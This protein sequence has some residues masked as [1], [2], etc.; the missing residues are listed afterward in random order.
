MNSRTGS[1][2]R[3]IAVGTI[4][5]AGGEVANKAATFLVYAML[6][7]MSGLEAFGQ[8]SLGLML[9]YTCHVFGYAGLPTVLVRLAARTPKSARFHFQHG[10]MAALA[11]SGISAL[12]MIAIAFAM[13]YQALTTQ[14]ICLLAIAVPFYS[15]SM[16]AEAIIKGRERMY[17]IPLGNL[18]GNILLVAG[19]L[20]ALGAG[21]GVLGVAAVVVAS[22]L[23]TMLTLYA[24]V[25]AIT[26]DC[27][28]RRFR[29]S[30]SFRLLS[31][32]RFFLGSDGLAAIGAS[33]S[34]LILSKFTNEGDVGILNASFQLMQPI[35][36]LYR[37]VGHSSFPSLV[38]A[39]KSG[40][41]SV[42][43]LASSL[44]GLIVRLSFPACLVMFSLAGDLLALA[45]GNEE[46]RNGAFVLQ[47]VAFGLLLDPL[48]A[49]LGH[50]LWAVGADRAV[51]RIAF[52]NVV[53][54]LIAGIVLTGSFGLTGAAICVV[55]T[56]V[57]NTGQHYQLF[58]RHVGSP[59]LAMEI[60]RILPAAL[61]SVAIVLLAP[62]PRTASLAIALIAYAVLIF[63]ISHAQAGSW[64]LLAK[65]SIL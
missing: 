26:A 34:G 59:G 52:I 17:L 46:F 22:R 23:V 36:I 58:I 6:S 2:I 11:T 41:Q 43:A 50:G 15:L 7:R 60:V 31:E 56:S 25:I 44:L 20:G 19:S 28:S 32:A 10:C 39:A 48:N 3:R 45:Y 51:F 47:V 57:V 5:I 62:L 33:L 42:T 14:V 37:S 24:M 38:A 49:I 1:A 54:A 53:F 12:A 29:L 35:Q 65:R 64:K 21:Y 18:P 30:H 9:F 61:L 40:K 55:L 63:W 27:T 8:L 13:R 4:H 16:I